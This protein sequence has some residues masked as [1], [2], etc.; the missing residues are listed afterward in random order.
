MRGIQFEGRTKKRREQAAQ[1]QKKPRKAKLRL[2]ALCHAPVV[3]QTGQFT[4]LQR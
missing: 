3:E 2:A 1:A 4:L